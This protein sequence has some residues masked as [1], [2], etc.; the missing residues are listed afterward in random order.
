MPKNTSSFFAYLWFNPP[1]VL[2]AINLIIHVHLSFYLHTVKMD[3]FYFSAWECKIVPT[4]FV[5][6]ELPKSVSELP[7]ASLE[8][9]VETTPMWESG[10]F[11]DEVIL[12]ITYMAFMVHGAWQSQRTPG[13]GLCADIWGI[14]LRQTSVW[15]KEW[16][17]TS[18]GTRQQTAKRWTVA[19]TSFMVDYEVEFTDYNNIVD[20]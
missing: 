18:S 10:A 5:G 14:Y 16:R 7:W 11:H 19:N 1:N 17:L 4:I 9:I 15:K 6:T 20:L 13:N 12:G 8:G 3:L 2:D